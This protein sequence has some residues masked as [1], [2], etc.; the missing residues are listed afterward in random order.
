MPS[1]PRLCDDDATSASDGDQDHFQ[2]DPDED[3]DDEDEDQDEDEAEDRGWWEVDHC[4]SGKKPRPSFAAVDHVA[5][6]AVVVD[7]VIVVFS[8]A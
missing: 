6:F 2:D 5:V 3:Q 7:V 8:A 4:G 1:L